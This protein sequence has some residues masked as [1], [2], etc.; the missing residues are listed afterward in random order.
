MSLPDPPPA[1]AASVRRV[2]AELLPYVRQHRG[3]I[4]LVLLLLAIA[5]L[6]NLGVP[7]SFKAIVDALDPRQQLIAV[8]A[9]LLAGYGLLRLLSAVAG[10]LRVI[11]FAKVHI[12]ARRRAALDS[13]RHL[14]NLGLRFHL[15]RRTGGLARVIERGTG[16]IEDFLY[17]CVIVIAPTLFEITIATVWMIAAYPASFALTMLA[18]LLAYVGVTTAGPR[19][20]RRKSLQ[21]HARRRSMTSS[22]VCRMATRLPWAS[23]A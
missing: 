13:F 19:R 14:H 23:A 8:P 7:I 20:R 21:P 4:A 1:A 12:G 18:T 2:L 15:E 10:E 9:L 22:K 16:A 5:K 3:R 11:L 6:A 17:D